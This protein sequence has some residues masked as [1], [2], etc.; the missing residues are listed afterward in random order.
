M[1]MLSRICYVLSL[2]C[3]Y[4]IPFA[5]FGF[6]SPLVHGKLDEGLTAVGL[7]GIIIIALILIGKFKKKVKDWAD[8]IPKAIIEPILNAVPLIIIAVLV[9]RLAPFID[10]LQVYLWRVV[11]C[12]IVGAFLEILSRILWRKEPTK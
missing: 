7:I 6:V 12:F 4:V 3:S 9:D 5:L 8:G 11:P 10:A 1:K 2:V